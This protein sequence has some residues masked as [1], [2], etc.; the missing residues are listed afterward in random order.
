A[1]PALRGPRTRD[2]G[3]RRS[4]SGR[5]SLSREPA[6]GRTRGLRLIEHIERTLR[7]SRRA[8]EQSFNRRNQHARD[9]HQLEIERAG[10]IADGGETRVDRCALEVRYLTLPQPKLR[11]EASLAQAPILADSSKKL[12]QRGRHV[13]TYR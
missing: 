6:L 4:Q 8:T 5:R 7:R 3:C 11:R 1:P 13:I 2:C 9:Q 12:G 10:H